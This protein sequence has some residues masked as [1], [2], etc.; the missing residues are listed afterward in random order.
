MAEPKIKYLKV[1][2]GIAALAVVASMGFFA[3]KHLLSIRQICWLR[4]KA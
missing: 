3:R 4:C 1:V 2:R